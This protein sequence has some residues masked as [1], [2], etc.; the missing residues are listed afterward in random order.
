[1]AMESF[2]DVINLWPSIGEFAR[3]TGVRQGLV[4]LW[5]YRDRIPG[6]YWKV[7]AE[8]GARRGFAGVSHEDLC[9]IG[10]KPEADASDLLSRSAGRVSDEDEA[11]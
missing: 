11:A 8:A 6:E 7:V 2:T 9:R 1:M 3:D 10:A 5:K 4:S